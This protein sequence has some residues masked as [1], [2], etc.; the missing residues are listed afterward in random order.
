MF[1]RVARPRD[2]TVVGENITD[3]PNVPLNQIREITKSNLDRSASYS[4]AKFD[5][6]KAKI[7][8]FQVGDLVLLKNEERNQTKLDPKYKGPFKVQ[9]IL[10]NDRYQIVSSTNR[11]TYKYAH[12]RLRRVPDT[13]ELCPSFDMSGISDDETGEIE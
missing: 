10:E 6:G 2:L 8:P 4:K 3:V 9:K 1:G 12:D 13:S 7:V 5:K 11:R